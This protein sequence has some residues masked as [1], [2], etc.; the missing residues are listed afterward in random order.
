V[1]SQTPD[2]TRAF[3]ELARVRVAEIDTQAMLTRIAELTTGTLPGASEV[4]VTLVQGESAHSAAFT[5]QTALK[6]DEIQYDQ[7][8][9]P[10]LDAA[11]DAHTV[12]VADM[13]AET[14]WPEFAEQAAEA[15]MLSSLSIGLPVQQDLI[16]ALNIYSRETDAF[17]G[18]TV[19]AAETFGSYAAIAVANVVSHENASTLA[20][21][22]QQAMQFR[23]VIEQAKGI[24]M[25][26]RKCDADEAFSV[27]VQL[28]QQTHTKLRSVCAALVQMSI[29]PDSSTR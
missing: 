22:M 24:I 26:Q 6:L 13:T 25:V 16:G 20:A 27:L 2:L 7:G 21:N 11:A 3:A 5:G 8:R 15:G 17:D 19:R 14:R 1:A 29:S 18:D 4:S 9:G 12:L 28:S 23:A 10:C